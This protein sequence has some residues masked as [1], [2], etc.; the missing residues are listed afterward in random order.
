MCWCDLVRVHPTQ[1]TLGVLNVLTLFHARPGDV[2]V[3]Q[4]ARSNACTLLEHN[5]AAPRAAE[6]LA[7]R[8]DGGE[9]AMTSSTNTVRPITRDL[10]LAG[11]VAVGGLEAHL[12]D[13][14]H[15]ILLH[16]FVCR[17]LILVLRAILL[18]YVIMMVG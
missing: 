13:F 9:P 15:Q 3:L 12:V 1:L 7:V 11:V 17:L 10:V 16:P 6:R 4:C 18:L 8:C 14:V 5:G 2:K